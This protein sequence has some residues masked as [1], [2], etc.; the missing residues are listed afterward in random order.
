MSIFL[1]IDGI[2]GC[3]SDACHP[4]WIDAVDLQWSVGRRITSAPSSRG[5]RES[6]NAEITALEITRFT[7]QATPQLFLEACCGRGRDITI[8]LTRTG[9][10]SGADTY[11]KYTLRHAMVSGYAIDAA[12]EDVTR[13][14]EK[15]IISFA[16]L[17]LVYTPFDQDG[18]PLAPLAVGFDTTTNT[19]L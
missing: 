3:A 18:R 13:P 14:L 17:E 2:N 1:R 7:D 5:S 9:T 19:R 4:G 10:G 6:S 16:A 11:L 8:E 15:I 12:A